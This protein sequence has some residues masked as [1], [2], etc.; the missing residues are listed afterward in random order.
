MYHGKIMD[1]TDMTRRYMDM[2]ME[3]GKLHQKQW[4]VVGIAPSTMGI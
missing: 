4:G 3:N 2:T 1:M